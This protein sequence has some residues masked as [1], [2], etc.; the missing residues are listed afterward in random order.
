MEGAKSILALVVISTGDSSRSWGS[1]APVTGLQSH[2]VIG[3]FSLSTKI[4]RPREVSYRLW[5]RKPFPIIAP[6]LGQQSVLPLIAKSNKNNYK[7][8]REIL[9]PS[10]RW[11]HHPRAL[12]HGP[13]TLAWIVFFA[14]VVVGCCHFKMSKCVAALEDDCSP[15]CRRWWIKRLIFFTISVA[16]KCQKTKINNLIQFVAVRF[17]TLV[18]NQPRLEDTCRN[19]KGNKSK[20]LHWSMLPLTQ[21]VKKKKKKQLDSSLTVYKEETPHGEFS[22]IPCRT[23]ETII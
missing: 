11:R 19:V 17:T 22:K 18:R 10:R 20:G 7:R 21:D 14:R 9:H 12:W 23:A 4:D 13:D 15:H 2:W 3:L 8:I 1:I 16:L 6:L 5:H